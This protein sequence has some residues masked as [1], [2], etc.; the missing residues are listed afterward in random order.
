MRESFPGILAI[1]YVIDN[2]CDVSS[3]INEELNNVRSGHASAMAAI[4][5]IMERTAP[6]LAEGKR[7]Y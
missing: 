1:P 3:L 6:V 2:W 7:I 5:R 4:T